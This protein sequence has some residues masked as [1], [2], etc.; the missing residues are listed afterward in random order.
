[1]SDMDFEQEQPQE[2]EASSGGFNI[3]RLLLWLMVFSLGALF[4]PLLLINTAIEQQAAPL[5]EELDALSTILA[6]TPAPPDEEVTLQAT[7]DALRVQVNS[8][9]PLSDSLTS[10][11][12]N[13]PAVMNAILGYDPQQITLTGMEQ[14]NDR[15]VVFGQGTDESQVMAYAQML[16]DSGQFYDIVVQSISLQAFTSRR[17]TRD[18]TS[19][20][21]TTQYADF[22]LA[23]TLVAPAQPQSSR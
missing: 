15:L 17:N 4:L 1:M 22:T 3:G 10:S 6:S 2:V 19:Q 20:E 8:L 9:A 13:W 18:E 5:A 12:V 11:H 14:N 23:I 21:D 16:R 7:L